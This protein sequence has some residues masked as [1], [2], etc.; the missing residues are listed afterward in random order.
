MIVIPTAPPA[1]PV[2]LIL[3]R[4]L[5]NLSDLAPRLQGE[6]YIWA[7]GIAAFPNGIVTES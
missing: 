1:P 6:C 4:E 2:P 7:N 5:G 3:Q